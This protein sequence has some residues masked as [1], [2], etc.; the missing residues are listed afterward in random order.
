MN[1][2]G[3]RCNWLRRNIFLL[4][5]IQV[6]TR[7]TGAEPLLIVVFRHMQYLCAKE[8]DTRPT[9]P[10]PYPARERN[11][12]FRAVI[13]VAATPSALA[14][15]ATRSAT[16]NTSRLLTQLSTEHSRYSEMTESIAALARI[17]AG[18]LG[19]DT[20]LFAASS[21]CASL[22]GELPDGTCR[23]PFQRQRRCR[24][25]ARSYRQNRIAL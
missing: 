16:R 25:Q 4:S 22:T 13:N 1:R 3:F 24:R 9:A 12:A 21:A 17:G 18:C 19:P 7:A 2:H 14:R 6:G 20:G 8:P 23:S 5:V 15:N 10:F 11:R